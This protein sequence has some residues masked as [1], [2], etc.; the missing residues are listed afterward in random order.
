MNRTDRLLAI[1]LE[2]QSRGKLRAEDL[3]EIFSVTKR[4]IYRDILALCGAGVAI[5]SIPGKGYTILDGYFLPPLSFTQDEATML[6]LGSDFVAQNFDSQYSNAASSAS[7]KIE[8]VLSKQLKDE[9]EYLKKSI[10]FVSISRADAKDLMRS[11]QIIRRAIIEKRTV[12][13]R[14]FKRTYE[15]S[16]PTE[17]EVDPLALVH[18]SGNWL[19]AGYCHLRKDIRS[20]RLSRMEKLSITEKTFSRP[21]NFR[22]EQLAEDDSPKIKVKVL[23]DKSIIRWISEYHPYRLISEKETAAGFA[24]TL[25]VDNESQILPWLLS[26]GSKIKVIFPQALQQLHKQEAEKLLWLYR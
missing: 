18:I 16:K 7:K 11:L 8:A 25:E 17:R 24:L 4:T 19:V 26:W 22:L 3:A 6:I 13:F 23:A 21:P 12:A 2:L 20:F 10:R 9:V 1:V 14:Y 15:T 5:D